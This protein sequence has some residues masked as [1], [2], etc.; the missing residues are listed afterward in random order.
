MRTMT[1]SRDTSPAPLSM[2]SCLR[3]ERDYEISVAWT[4]CPRG[5]ARADA[6]QVPV[7]GTTLNVTRWMPRMARMRLM[8]LST[9]SASPLVMK[10]S[11]Q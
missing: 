6:C 8:K 4:T 10:I 9:C 3:V 5:L 2:P 11:R 7:S 1:L